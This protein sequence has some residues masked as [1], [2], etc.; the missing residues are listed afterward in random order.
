MSEAILPPDPLSRRRAELLDEEERG[1]G[2]DYVEV[3]AADHSRLTVGLLRDLPPGADPWKL[4]SRPDQVLVKGGERVRGIRVRAVAVADARTLLVRTDRPG[5]FSRYEL[6]LTVPDLDPVLRRIGFSFMAACPSDLDCRT[7]G[8][9]P[10]DPGGP[11][12]LLD[13]AAKD[14]AGFRRMLLDLAAQRHPSLSDRHPADPAVTLLELLAFHADQLSYAQDA[15]LLEGYLGLARRR[16]SVRRHVRLVDYALH[17]GRNAATAVHLAVDAPVTVP[18]GTPLLTAVPNPLPGER[19][20]PRPGIRADLVDRT[21][22][23]TPPLDGSV[24]FETAHELTAD[25]LGNLLH[26]HH[27]GE[28]AYWLPAGATTAWLWAENPAQPGTAAEPVLKAGDLLVLEQVR[29]PRTGLAADADPTARWVVRLTDVQ[30]GTDPAYLPAVA[31]DADGQVQLTERTHD[32][33]PQLPL[34]AVRW[35]AAEAPDRPV[36]VR[37]VQTDGDVLE[38]VSLARGNTVLADHGATVDGVDITPDGWDPTAAGPLGGPLDPRLRLPDA[39]LTH[40]AGAPGTERTDLSGGPQTAVP[41][42]T[43]TARP[44]SGPAEVYSPVPDLFDSGPNDLHL[45]VEVDDTGHG[46]IRFGRPPLGR[47]PLQAETFEARYRIGNGTAGNIGAEALAHI[48]LPAADADHVQTVRNPVPASGGTEPESIEHARRLAPDAFRARQERAV[49]EKDAVD[50]VLR[51]PAV[52]AAVAALRWT[53]SWYTW[54]VSVLPVDPAAL[55]DTG[56]SHQEL[57][58]GLRAQVVAA[59]DAV[60]LAGQDVDVRPP[61]FVAVELALHVCAAPGRSRAVVRRAVRDALLAGRLPDGRPGLLAGPSLG[62]GRPLL[63]GEVYAAAAAVPG[64]D[65]VKALT[66]RRYDAPDNGELAAGR[67]DVAPWQVLRLDDDPSLPEH[68]VL[69]LEIDGGTP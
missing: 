20:A 2:I 59:L 36:C 22:L 64:V 66:L 9:G 18:R 48:V 69:R 55:V 5:D 56:G 27:W 67:L 26:L 7:P 38:D 21:A 41:A 6:E 51:L 33:D 19:G 3:D 60:R 31:L 13:G 49:T 1:N 39:P 57:S 11:E 54:L 25:P 53:G 14:F 46:L 37:A 29:S 34:L 16:V 4:V 43:V 24:V 65:S 58:D 63:L 47:P 35:A 28:D 40:Q 45:V 68:G 10:A 62:F 30:P 32:A 42:L 61:Q 44:R 17:Q 23:A 12:P 52:R 8:S 15:A 50:A